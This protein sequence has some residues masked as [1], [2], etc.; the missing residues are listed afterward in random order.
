MWHELGRTEVI[1]DNLN[2]IFVKGFQVEYKFE[3]R[4]RFKVEAYDVDDFTPNAPLNKHDYIG[5][6]EFMLHEVVT[7][8][9]QTFKKP[10]SN[11]K[12]PHRNNG[13]LKIT[14]DERSGQNNEMV[15][16]EVT[17]S[18]SNRNGFNFFIVQKN[19]GPNHYVPIY[20]SEI[21]Q[22]RGNQFCWSKLK[23]LT[24]NLCKEEE[25]REIRIDF[26]KN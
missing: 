23:S 10:F 3:E 6:C 22:I 16:M 8:R 9:D 15:E 25:D 21:Q 4:Q 2:P 7:S 12:N 26:Y 11:S 20:K 1:M 24:S 5:E 13:T 14:A 18:F 17:A 19:L